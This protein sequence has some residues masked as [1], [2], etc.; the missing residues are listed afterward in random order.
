MQLLHLQ[1]SPA[2]LLAAVADAAQA[3]T[4]ELQ[5]KA[6]SMV[7]WLLQKLP[8]AQLAKH[9]SITAGLLAIPSIPGRLAAELCYSGVRIPYTS[10]VAAARARVEGEA[11]TGGYRTVNRSVLLEWP[12][13][14]KACSQ[15]LQDRVDAMKAVK[16]CMRCTAVQ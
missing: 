5:D 7:T 9:P 14:G 2:W 11:V 8:E 1:P 15:H 10:I 13:L 12:G 4:R 6:I 3:E 16:A